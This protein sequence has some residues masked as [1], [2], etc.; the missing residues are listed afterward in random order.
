[1]YYNGNMVDLERFREVKAIISDFDDTLVATF[2]KIVRIVDNFADTLGVEPPGETGLL[3]YWGKPMVDMIHG[4]F[5]KKTPHL[6]PEELLTQYK[7]SVPKDFFLDPIEGIEE[8]VTKLHQRGYL[9]GIVSSGPKGSILKTLRAHY[10]SLEK[11]YTFIHGEEDLLFK[12]PDPRAFDNAFEVLR[13]MGVSER[14]A[15][16]VGDFHSDYDAAINRG[17]LFIGIEAHQRSKEWFI[18]RGLDEKLRLPSF[19]CI[20]NFFAAVHGQ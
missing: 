14:Q 2:P 15:V 12:K 16:Y 5:G 18:Q 19:S 1:M 8:S 17:M 6:T 4:L 9:Q 13:S 20:P 11:R 3:E 7:T 10:P